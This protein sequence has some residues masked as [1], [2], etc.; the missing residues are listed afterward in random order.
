MAVGYVHYGSSTMFVYT[1]GR[2]VH[3]FTLDPTMGEFHLANENLKFPEK[4]NVYSTNEGNAGSWMSADI[5]WVNWIK[6]D[7]AD[8]S[9]L[10]STG[11]FC[12]AGFLPIRGTFR[13]QTAS[14]GFFTSALPWL[15]SQSSPGVPPPMASN[16]FSISSRHRPTPTNTAVHRHSERG[17]VGRTLP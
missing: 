3:V 8:T 13:S 4:S 16:E 12:R 6:E 17:R 10:T 9:A 7:D 5:D 15:S 11:F 2:G 1:K 14:C